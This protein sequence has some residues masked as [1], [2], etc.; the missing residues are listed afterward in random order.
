MAIN[1]KAQSRAY[2]NI[3]IPLSLGFGIESIA[4]HQSIFILSL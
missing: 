2:F 4:C 3:E 1:T